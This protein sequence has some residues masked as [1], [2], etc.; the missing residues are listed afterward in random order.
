MLD[1]ALVARACAPAHFPCSITIL[2]LPR[3]CKSFRLFAQFPTHCSHSRSPSNGVSPHRIFFSHASHKIPIGGEE[4]CQS[5]IKE[6]VGVLRPH[7]TS[8]ISA[9]NAI[10]ELEAMATMGFTTLRVVGSSFV[11]LS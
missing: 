11:M 1:Y 5:K 6:A 9:V 2:L 7:L 4:G 3:F 10:Q 8:S